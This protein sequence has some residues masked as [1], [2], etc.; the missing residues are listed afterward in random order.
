MSVI[1]ECL[2]T[3]FS[4]QPLDVNESAIVIE[5]RWIREYPAFDPNYIKY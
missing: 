3:T 5:K 4:P 1:V 2:M